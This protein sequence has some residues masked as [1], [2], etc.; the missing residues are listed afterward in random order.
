M[1][2]PRECD[3]LQQDLRPANMTLLAPRTV[4]RVGALRYGEVNMSVGEWVNT[5]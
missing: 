4:L 2:P 5:P 1:S 3:F